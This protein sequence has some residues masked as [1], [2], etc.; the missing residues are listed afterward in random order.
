MLPCRG[1]RLAARRGLERPCE[2]NVLA[3]SR[4]HVQPSAP[5]PAVRGARTDVTR[6]AG[7]G[8]V[9][10]IAVPRGGVATGGA[11]AGSPLPSGLAEA[12]FLRGNLYG[13]PGA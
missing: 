6:D 7:G 4:S 11:A 13:E 1:H 5:R 2:V 8:A 3:F 9:A 12:P 10:P